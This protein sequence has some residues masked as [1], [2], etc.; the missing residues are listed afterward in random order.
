MYVFITAPNIIA[1]K[2]F[3]Q[4]KMFY[5]NFRIKSIYRPNAKGK[6]AIMDVLPSP[7]LETGRRCKDM[8]EVI[9]SFIVSVLASVVA[10]YICKW[11]D[12]E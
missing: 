9:G 11:L 5:E 7:I 4:E 3:C 1:V 8:A 12:R 10:Y 6:I 2:V